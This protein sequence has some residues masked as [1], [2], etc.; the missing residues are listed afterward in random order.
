MRLNK[1][2]IKL[3]KKYQDTK[4][5]TIGS[6]RCKHYPSCS[7]YSIACYEKFN[8]IKA[9]FLTIFRIIRCNPLTK[10]TYDP[11]P[12]SKKEKKVLKEKYN[13]LLVIV[14]LI[15]EHIK[16]DASLDV[17]QCISYIYDYTFKDGQIT[18]ELITLYYDYIYVFKKEIKKKNILLDYKVVSK[19]IDLYLSKPF[20]KK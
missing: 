19:E 9:S 4:D 5:M 11:V 15:N 17:N 12:L 10:K 18:D 1:F 2:V 16:N 6:G 7:N 3:I 14:P 20:C 8:F 13:K